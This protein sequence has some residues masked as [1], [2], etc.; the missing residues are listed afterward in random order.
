MRVLF[1][2]ATSA[3]GVGRH[4]HGLVRSLVGTGVE[5]VVACPAEA[6][7]SFG[8]ADLARVVPLEVADRPQPLHDARAVRELA[9]LAA[10]ADVVHAHGLR[11]GALVCLALARRRVPVVTTLHNAAPSGR[12]SAAVYAALERVVAR[13]SDLV[14]GVSPDLVER[15]RAL[16]A[17]DTGAA[18]VPAPPHR[19]PQRDR[20]ALHAELGIDARTALGV[21]V[22]RLAPQKG[23]D[24]LLD[25]HHDLR[26]LDLLTVVAGDGPLREHLEERIAGE[27]LPV[28]LLGRREDVPDLLAAADVVVS[29]AVW[30]GQP[31]ALQ[32]ALHAGAAIVATE[33]GGTAA[34]VGEA[35]VLVRPGDPV[36]LARAVRDVVTHGGVRDDLRSKA[37]EQS[38][39]LPDEADALA[40]AL[41]AYE[42]VRAGASAGRPG[43]R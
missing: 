18:V 33:V 3:G 21:V 7:A 10:G 40:A 34:V 43:P 4:V 19:T 14:L 22:A 23:L 41:A 9:H 8:F 15:M 35:A 16:G 5:V 13:R 28:R 26:D 38:D 30:E 32:E 25:A 37:V 27:D 24:L 1:V 29:S 20:F 42:S 2:L 6:A 12:A 36:A 11:A 31:V 17:R 39:A